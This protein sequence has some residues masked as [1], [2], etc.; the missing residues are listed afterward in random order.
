MSKKLKGK[1]RPPL[2]PTVVF[3]QTNSIFDNSQQK[4]LI[5]GNRNNIVNQSQSLND[6]YQT[7]ASSTELEMI[8]KENKSLKN[9][10]EF[11]KHQL[12]ITQSLLEK[13]LSRK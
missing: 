9:E 10:V 7:N 11:L 2:K 13:A 6:I 4:S 1:K 8:R 5:Q 12:E 3:L